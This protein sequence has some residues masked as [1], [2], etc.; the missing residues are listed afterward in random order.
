MTDLERLH[1]E[2]AKEMKRIDMLKNTISLDVDF[3]RSEI[4]NAKCKIIKLYE[5]FDKEYQSQNY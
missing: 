5:E 2:I 3:M 1:K 4:K